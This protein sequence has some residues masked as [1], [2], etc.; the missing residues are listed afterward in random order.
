MLN[1]RQIP[2]PLKSNVQYASTIVAEL[3]ER[4]NSERYFTEQLRETGPVMWRFYDHTLIK[5]LRKFWFP[6]IVGRTTHV[7]GAINVTT[8]TLDNTEMSQEELDSLALWN[9]QF[10]KCCYIISNLRGV[11]YSAF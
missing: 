5:K 11:G 2:P 1:Y 4:S 7:S 10:L 6:K 9:N 8:V 3:N